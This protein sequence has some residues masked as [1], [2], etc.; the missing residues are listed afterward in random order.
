M[1]ILTYATDNQHFP[2][3]I[4]T[5][6][7]EFPGTKPSGHPPQKIPTG[8]FLVINSPRFQLTITVHG[9]L[10]FLDHRVKFVQLSC[11]VSRVIGASQNALLLLYWRLFAV[12]VSCK[13]IKRLKVFF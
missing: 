10:V 13:V 11:I 4:T 3:K 5:I 6:P 9:L 2:V 7:E 12:N 1:E 8:H